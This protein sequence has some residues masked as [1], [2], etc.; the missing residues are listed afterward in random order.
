M[1]D[2]Q[3]PT[4]RPASMTQA[5]IGIAVGLILGNAVA[6]LGSLFGFYD[7][8]GF[9]PV[10]ILAVIWIAVAW[11]WPLEWHSWRRKTR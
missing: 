1:S 10:C 9:W 11:F 7:Y 8:N 5:N 2:A 6:W 4:K 3:G